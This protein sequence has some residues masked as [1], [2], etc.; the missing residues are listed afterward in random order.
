MKLARRGFLGALFGLPALKFPAGLTAVPSVAY[1]AGTLTADGLGNVSAFKRYAGYEI[2]NIGPEDVFA[3]ADYKWT[4]MGWGGK[5]R[6][7][8]D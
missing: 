4:E 2:L 5:V 8:G 6:V 1:G 3:P 7:S